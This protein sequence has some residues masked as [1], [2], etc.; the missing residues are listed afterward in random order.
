MQ[1]RR[2]TRKSVISF[3]DWNNSSRSHTDMMQISAEPSR[4]TTVSAAISGAADY[5]ALCMV[6][7]AE[8]KHLAELKK[9]RQYRSDSRQSNTTNT[10]PE[11]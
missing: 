9:R 1:C 4:G 5:Q 7:K 8:E 2:R 11:S 6:A 10:A 3:A